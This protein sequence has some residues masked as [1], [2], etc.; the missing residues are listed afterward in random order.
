MAVDLGPVRIPDW[1]LTDRNKHV[2]DKGI[3][4]LVDTEIVTA[5]ESIRSSP[6]L[7]CSHSDVAW[8]RVVQ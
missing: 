2:Y 3:E 6:L 8:R 7:S 1:T 4:T 5:Q